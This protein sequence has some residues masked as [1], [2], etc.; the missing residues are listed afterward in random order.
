MKKCAKIQI[1]FKIMFK[2]NLYNSRRCKK[3]HEKYNNQ[4]LRSKMSHFFLK[5]LKKIKY[6]KADIK[7]SQKCIFIKGCVS[8]GKL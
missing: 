8:I 6:L 4:T 3:P 5:S 2:V 7:I 1:T